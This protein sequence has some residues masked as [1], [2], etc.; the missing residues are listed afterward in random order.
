[1]PPT[2]HHLTDYC[3]YTGDSEEKPGSHFCGSTGICIPYIGKKSY[4]CKCD[5]GYANDPSILQ[6]NCA[7]KNN[8][9]LK[10]VCLNYGLCYTNGIRA[11]CVCPSSWTGDDCGIPNSMWNSWSQWSACFPSCGANSRSNRKRICSFSRGKPCPGS[12]IQYR[13]CTDEQCVING[14]WDN[15]SPWTECT[16]SCNGGRMARYRDCNYNGN[17]ITNNTKLTKCVGPDSEI[18]Y[19]NEHFCPAKLQGISIDS[20]D[21]IIPELEVDIQIKTFQKVTTVKDYFG[22]SFNEFLISLIAIL[23]VI[24]IHLISLLLIFSFLRNL[25]N[26]RFEKIFKP[27]DIREMRLTIVELNK[28][29]DAN[30]TAD[31][32]KQLEKLITEEIENES[33]KSIKQETEELVVDNKSYYY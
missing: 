18:A 13:T 2:C 20:T 3:T 31:F 25:R 19:C 9:C 14:I 15:W 10:V 12:H 8:P 22:K 24:V 6:P 1:M 5:K 16:H 32:M 30:V 28:S 17:F 23:F 33:S 27:E 29:D 11:I 26:L 7:M 21:G 4:R